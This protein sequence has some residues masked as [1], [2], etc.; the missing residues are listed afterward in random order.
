[1]IDVGPASE[2]RAHQGQHLATGS[3]PT[4]S[5]DQSDHLVHQ[6]L[7]TQADHKRG[8]HDQSGVGNKG[9]LVEDHLDPVETARY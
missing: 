4:H 1:M 5:T 8:H 9:W 6:L 3:G 7:E 2:D